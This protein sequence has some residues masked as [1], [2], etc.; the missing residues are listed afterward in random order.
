MHAKAK[1]KPNHWE[2]LPWRIIYSSR[3]FSMKA[4]QCSYI[5]CPTPPHTPHWPLYESVNHEN[6][7]KYADCLLLLSALRGLFSVRYQSSG[8][9]CLK[10]GSFFIFYLLLFLYF[11]VPPQSACV[12][13]VLL[14]YLSFFMFCFVFCWFIFEAWPQ[15]VKLQIVSAANILVSFCMR[16]I[17]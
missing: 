1:L 15:N 12:L 3:T 6:G 2:L 10:C 14:I 8:Y 4:G 9:E 16:L 17:I 13:R 5:I 7:H 11:V